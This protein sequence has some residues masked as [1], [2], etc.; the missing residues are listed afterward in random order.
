[1]ALADRIT[2]QERRTNGERILGLT[3][4][5]RRIAPAFSSTGLQ[6]YRVE[7][8]DTRAL[9]A[10][11]VAHSLATRHPRSP[12]VTVSLALRFNQE[13]YTL[14]LSTH[15]KMTVCFLH[16]DT[17][18]RATRT[19]DTHTPSETAA[20]LENVA[21]YCELSPTHSNHLCFDTAVLRH[22]ITSIAISFSI[23]APGTNQQIALLVYCI[24]SKKALKTENVY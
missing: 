24:S 9:T 21:H 15:C 10:S 8:K 16:R 5:P 14:L 1:M 19:A 20:S 2:N 17:S 11:L 12:H 23:V 18:A 6:I 7:L 22:W 3:H 4:L 13:K